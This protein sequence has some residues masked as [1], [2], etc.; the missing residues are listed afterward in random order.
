[1]NYM[2]INHRDRDSRQ[3]GIAV[4]PA[5]LAMTRSG[6]SHRCKVAG[7]NALFLRCDVTHHAPQH[8]VDGESSNP[9]PA[10][11]VKHLYVQGCTTSY[12]HDVQYKLS[13]NKPAVD[14]RVQ[15]FDGH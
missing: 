14:F 10:H 13:G 15:L 11:K 8:T 2:E 1:M 4:G 7:Y 3:I 6:R 5:L 9:S 12:G